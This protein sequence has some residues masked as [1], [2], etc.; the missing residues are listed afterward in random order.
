[1]KEGQT[2]L[3]FNEGVMWEDNPF[4]VRINDECNENSGSPCKHCHS[5]QEKT[6]KNTFGV[7]Y[8]EKTWI[9]PVVIVVTNEGGYNSTGLCLDCLLDAVISKNIRDIKQQ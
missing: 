2:V 6:H 9:C 8:I 7:T 5:H 1:M 4:Q 3:T